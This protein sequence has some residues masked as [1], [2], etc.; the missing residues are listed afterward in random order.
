M[1]RRSNLR[2]SK[3]AETCSQVVR[4]WRFD[5]DH[6]SPSL[7]SSSFHAGTSCS[8]PS[9]LRS[10]R[11]LPKVRTRLT[12]V[13]LCPFVGGMPGRHGVWS[14]DAARSDAG[15]IIA[16]LKNGETPARP[17]EE[18]GASSGPTIAELAEQY[19]ADHVAVRCK[20][21]T[22]RSCRHIF[23][24]HLLPQVGRLP[25]MASDPTTWRP[26]GLHKARQSAAA[27]PRRTSSPADSE[28]FSP[29][30]GSFT[31]KSLFP[32]QRMW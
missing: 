6:D 14:L 11:Q 17:G 30:F 2:E 7:S 5:S 16:R 1:D 8:R 19:M 20:P 29:V 28:A 3:A 31:M 12:R 10:H 9:L 21:T 4:A 18:N 15:G 23:D 26:R 24:R 25:S 32:A 22:E 27:Q 13:R